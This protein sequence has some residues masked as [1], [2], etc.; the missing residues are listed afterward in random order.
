VQ[1]ARLQAVKALLYLSLGRGPEGVAASRLALTINP[2]DQRPLLRRAMYYTKVR[3]LDL[4]RRD[5]ESYLEERPDDPRIHLLHGMLLVSAGLQE[6]AA[7]A[8]RRVIELN[9]RDW[10][11]A[12]NLAWILEERGE[13]DEALAAASH[14]YS[15]AAEN[16]QVI[17]TMGFMALRTGQAKRAVE[18]LEKANEL[19]PDYL[20]MQFHLAEAYGAV[21]RSGEGRRLLTSMK[22]RAGGNPQVLARIAELQAGLP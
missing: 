5:C 20:E 9:P 16:P 1:E 2:K 14:A 8:Y 4:A 11:A 10:I 19:A 3:R 12:N 18:L 13:F 21:G 15:H 17:D 6:E 7:H 22:S